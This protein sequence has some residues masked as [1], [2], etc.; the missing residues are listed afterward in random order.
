MVRVGVPREISEAAGTT[1]A[2]VM[3]Q[4]I[5][6]RNRQTSCPVSWSDRAQPITSKSEP[7]NS[8]EQYF[9]NCAHRPNHLR[10]VRCWTQTIL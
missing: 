3:V 7:R 10:R 9:L 6:R 4:Q 1:D 5:T 8:P 2:L